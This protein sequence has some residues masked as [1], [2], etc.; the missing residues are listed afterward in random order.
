[1]VKRFNLENLDCANCAA[2]LERKVQGVKGI[3][4]ANVSFLAQKLTIEADEKE[5][6]A[7]MAEVVKVAKKT[8]P[9]CIIKL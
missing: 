4:R 7:I 5:F 9:D 1:M 8:V 2:K 6:D 3:I